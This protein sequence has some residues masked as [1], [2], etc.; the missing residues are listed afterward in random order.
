MV[1]LRKC[2]VFFFIP[3]AAEG[4]V[5][6]SAKCWVG[7]LWVTHA[8]VAPTSGL[9]CIPVCVCTGTRHAEVASFWPNGR[10]RSK[11]VTNA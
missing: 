3:V 9:S 7:L 2:R 10:T 8:P 11:R 4:V 1:C 6:H 5:G